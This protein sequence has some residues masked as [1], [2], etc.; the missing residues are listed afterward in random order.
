MK[1]L[2]LTLAFV[3]ATSFSFAGINSNETRLEKTP[4]A[5]EKMACFDFNDSCGGS[6]TVCSSGV[7]TSQLMSFLW[8]WD[9]G[10]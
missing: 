10:C 1:N 7:S 5:V 3:F 2:F 8:E 6:W 9:G 4:E